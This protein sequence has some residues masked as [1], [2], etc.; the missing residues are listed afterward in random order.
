MMTRLWGDEIIRLGEGV[1]EPE[2]GFTSLWLFRVKLGHYHVTKT[3]DRME[4]ARIGV[5]AGRD[6]WTL[7][8]QAGRYGRAV[9]ISGGPE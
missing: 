7:S 9:T 1:K 3:A 8:E 6:D 4:R 5:Q 2:P